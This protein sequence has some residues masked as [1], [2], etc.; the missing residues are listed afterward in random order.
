MQWSSLVVGIALSATLLPATALVVENKGYYQLSYDENSDLG[1]VSKWFG[2]AGFQG[3]G[4]SFNDGIQVLSDGGGPASLQVHLPSF[5]LSAA[6]GWTLSNPAAFLG[7]LAFTEVGG[8]VTSILAGADVELDGHAFR[9]DQAVGWT[10]TRSGVASNVGYF[11]GNAGLPGGFSSLKVS[12]ATLVLNASG[13]LFGSI[14][15]TDQNV[16]EISFNVSAVPEPAGSA[17]LASGLGVI[18][19]LL[20]RRVRR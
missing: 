9:Y 19:W 15:A 2:G 5:T 18:A 6:G 13:G 17:M 10:V 12:N 7:K 14:Q 11:S 8:S 20:R 4:W 1:G 3:F 16:L